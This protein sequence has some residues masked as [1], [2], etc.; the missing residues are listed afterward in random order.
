MKKV[1]IV[2]DEPLVRRGLIRAARGRSVQFIEAEDGSQGLQL[3]LSHKPDLVIVDVLMP[4]LSGPELLRTVEPDVKR[5]AKIVL[6]SAFTGDF[7]EDFV[8]T[9][10]ADLFIAKPFEDIFKT[11][12]TILQLISESSSEL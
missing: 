6:I 10:G 9:L 1:L 2:D 5:Q 11:V 7:N 12:D 4:G 8:K 3:W